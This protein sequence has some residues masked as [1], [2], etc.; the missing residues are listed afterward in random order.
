MLLCLQAYPSLAAHAAPLA[1]FCRKTKQ[2]PSNICLRTN[3]HH[4][5]W[6]KKLGAKEACRTN[7]PAA[8]KDTSESTTK[9][10][11]KQLIVTR[12]RYEEPKLSIEVLDWL[13]DY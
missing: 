9:N 12:Q 5:C 8:A 1:N 10:E 3:T 6:R 11:T 13:H 2:K 4:I 7:E